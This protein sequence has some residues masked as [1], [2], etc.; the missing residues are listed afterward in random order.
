L[1]EKLTLTGEQ[2]EKMR[3]L[4]SEEVK[5]MH[6][7]RENHDLSEADRIGKEK[8]FRDA[9]RPKFKAILSEEQFE[10]FE[11]LRGSKPKKEAKPD[12]K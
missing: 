1:G 8:E 7:L 6:S 5:F 12:A 3:P 4:I 11:K 10:K 9:S 2:K